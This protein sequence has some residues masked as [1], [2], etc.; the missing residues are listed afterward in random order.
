M[1]PFLSAPD[2]A[3]VRSLP[4]KPLTAPGTVGRETIS[5]VGSKRLRHRQKVTEK[6]SHSSTRGMVWSSGR[7]ETFPSLGASGPFPKGLLV[8]A[9]L[10]VTLALVAFVALALAN[11]HWF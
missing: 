5:E 9:F 3:A 8:F 2:C 1:S 4:P 6:R 10:G 11:H 7:S